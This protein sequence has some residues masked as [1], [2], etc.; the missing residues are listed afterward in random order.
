MH[1]RLKANIDSHWI[2][3]FQQP[4]EVHACDLKKMDWCNICASLCTSSGGP[5]KGK[6]VLKNRRL[7][8]EHISRDF[9]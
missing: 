1:E 7:L 4:R 2:K 3:Y 6:H 9:E 5:R 8:D